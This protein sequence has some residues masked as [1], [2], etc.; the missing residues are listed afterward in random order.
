[1][2]QALRSSGGNITEQHI[3]DVS[4]SALFLMEA[5]KLESRS[6][7]GVTPQTSAHMTRNAE[8]DIDKMVNHLIQKNVTTE[9]IGRLTPEFSDPTEQGWK[10]L[11]STDWLQGTLLKANTDDLGVEE[12]IGEVDLD[13]ELYDI[14]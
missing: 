10:K 9:V 4:L 2:K 5:A 6:S 7:I 11:C 13:Y 8:N 1:M 3:V 12:E 14:V